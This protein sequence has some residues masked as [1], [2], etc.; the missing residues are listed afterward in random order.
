MFLSS[1][2][3]TKY[4]FGFFFMEPEHK[5]TQ[6][7]AGQMAQWVRSLGIETWRPEFRFW[8]S[9]LK[10]K[11]Q[12]RLNMSVTPTLGSQASMELAGFR[13][14]LGSERNPGKKWTELRGTEQDT[15][16]LP[17]ASSSTC[18]CHMHTHSMCTRSMHTC[19]IH[20]HSMHTCN[21]HTHSIR[22]YMQHAHMQHAYM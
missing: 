2:T 16:S 8:H 12:V 18:T 10:K 11:S 15:R 14:A 13:L 5:N 21:M 17:L 1:Y 9:Y 20:T 7:V 6:S 22:T 4:L 3:F 19:S